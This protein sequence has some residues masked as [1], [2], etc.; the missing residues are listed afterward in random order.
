[1]IYDTGDTH[2]Q[3]PRWVEH[4]E[5][6]LSDGDYIIINGD[7]GVGFWD[8]PYWPEEMFYDHVSEQNYNVLFIDGNH[9]N[10]DKLDSY[11][12]ELW[13]GGKV[14]K[15][16]H[17]LIHLMRGEV[18][19]I[20]GVRIFVFGGAFSSD[21]YRRKEGI[22]WWPEQELPSEEDEANAEE[23][24]SKAGYKVDYIITHT[25]PCSTI[26]YIARDPGLQANKYWEE[27]HHLTV[28]LEGIQQRVSYRHWYCGHLHLDCEVWRDLTIVKDSI[29]ELKSGRMVNEWK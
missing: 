16:R 28:F 26:E 8:G 19:D 2:G 5:P 13:N 7:F 3:Q 12:V 4:I 14:H 21:Y 6:V 29:Y 25:A 22:S 10:F 17:N 27:E 20:E 18:Y 24:L 9:E 15:I 1:M 11:P 23:N